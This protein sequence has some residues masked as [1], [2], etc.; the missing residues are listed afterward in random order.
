MKVTVVSG[1]SDFDSSKYQNL[2]SLRQ[3]LDDYSNVF[4]KEEIET[5]F[6]RL[7]YLSKELLNLSPSLREEKMEKGQKE[8]DELFT[9]QSEQLRSQLMREFFPD[10]LSARE[11]DL[12]MDDFQAAWGKKFDIRD[13]FAAY[14]SE[15]APVKTQSPMELF[16]KKFSVGAPSPPSPVTGARGVDPGLQQALS[17]AQGW[18]QTPGLNAT[19]QRLINNLIAEID[20]LIASGGTMS[21]L[22]TW[23]SN[24]WA[25]VGGDI[26]FYGQPN[27]R[28]W[29]GIFE[30]DVVKLFTICGSI[31]PTFSQMDDLISEADEWLMSSTLFYS[32]LAIALDAEIFSVGAQG[33]P[34][35]V[36]TWAQQVVQNNFEICPSIFED[37]SNLATF[38]TMTGATTTLMVMWE[39]VK[40]QL[41]LYPS[42]PNNALYTDALAEIN[43]LIEGGGSVSDFEQWFSSQF[44]GK[45]D[46][47]MQYL[48]FS[49]TA[50]QA[51]FD[52]ALRGTLPPP[53]AMDTAYLNAYNWRA[54]L[55]PGADYNLADELVKEIYALGS[56]AS[57]DSLIAW[58]NN[59]FATH[60]IYM[61]NPDAS[62]DALNEFYTITG[63]GPLPGITEMDKIYQYAWEMSKNYPGTPDQALFIA[64]A[65]EAYSLGSNGNPATVTAW[66]QHL[67]ESGDPDF[68][69][70]TTGTQQ[71]FINITSAFLGA[72]Y[73][74]ALEWY[75]S[76][77][78]PN[79]AA[80]QLAAALLAE[81]KSLGDQGT[82]AQLKAWFSQTFT[83]SRDVYWQYLGLSQVDANT[84]YAICQEG[85]APVPT[86]MDGTYKSVMDWIGSLTPGSAD[87]LLAQKLLAEIQT[88]GSQ[89]QQSDLTAW[90]NSIFGGSQ[91]IYMQNPDA[92]QA[93]I[94]QFYSLAGA[95]I[96]PAITAM[97]QQYKFVLN[98]RAGLQPGSADYTLANDLANEILSLGS[99]GSATA[100]TAWAQQL[101]ESGFPD[102]YNASAA[103][104]EKFVQFTSA[105]LAAAYQQAE[106]WFNSTAPNSAAH[107]LAAALLAEIKSLG[108]QG[109]VDQ[110]KAWF[111]QT[112]TASK[113]VYWQYLGL[114]QTD[115][116]TFYAICQEGGAPPPTAMDTIY[117]NVMAW[118]ASLLPG[119]ADALL[120]QKLLAEIQSLGS[121]GTQSTLNSWISNTF[122]GTQDIYMQNPDASQAAINQFYSLA[123]AGAPTAITAMDQQYK[124]AFDWRAGLQS[125]SA[126]Y[127]LADDLVNEIFSLGSS[128]SAAALTAW[129]QH[130]IE[131]G[132]PD[133]YNASA[134]AQGKFVQFT[135]AWL[136]AAYQQ[137]EDW[138][139]STAPNSAAHQ[140]AATLLAE[141]KSLGDQ[142]TVDQL[143]AWFS[144]TFTASRD[145]YWQYLGLSQADANT[146]YAICQEGGAP[147][148]TAMD[149]IY[150]NVTTWIASLPPG[151]ADALLAQK[152]LTE[153][154]SLGSQGTQ[155][156]LSGWIS[157]TFGGT[158]DIYMQNPDASQAAINQI[159]SLAGAG[160]PPTMTTMDQQYKLAFDW[161]AGLQSG[162]A[163]YVLANDLVN[164]IFSL[165]SSGSVTTLTAWAQHLIKSDFPDYYNAPSAAQE[166]FVQF[167]FAWLG[168][169]YQ[170]AEDW[171]N[172]TTPNSPARQLAIALL[173]EIQALGDQ[174]TIDQLKAWFS[175]TFSASK[176]V[177]WQ[178]LGL[179]QTDANTFYAICQEGGAPPPTAMDTIYANVMAWV[180]SLPPGTIDAL[181]AQ[182]LL[183]EVQSLGSQGTQ[184]TLNG[185]MNTTF[186]IQDIYMQNPDAS[187]TAIDQFYLLAGAG[188]P[189]PMT[190]ADQKY[191]LAYDWRATLQ[192]GSV[193][194][195]LANDLTDQ[196]FAIGSAGSFATVTAWAQGIVD[197]NFANYPEATDTAKATFE[198]IADTGPPTDPFLGIKTDIQA[199]LTE[200]ETIF[201]N[202]LTILHQPYPQTPAQ[203]Q[204]L[205]K[206]CQA[207]A[208][209]LQSAMA[210]CHT[211]AQWLALG[212]T[213][214]FTGTPQ[215]IQVAAAARV[216]AYQGVSGYQ[217]AI[218][219]FNNVLDE[220]N[221]LENERK[222]LYVLQTWASEVNLNTYSG[223]S[224][225][226]IG[227]FDKLLAL[228]Q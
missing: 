97:D 74:Q 12:Y 193:D 224:A 184:S 18:L 82:V 7:D 80:Y 150:A 220:I 44:L 217:S 5:A 75:N 86:A 35:T 177:Y 210:Q 205:I 2:N 25:S 118:V 21:D 204:L 201:S 101:I 62:W 48:G 222:P 23:L 126:D 9:Q 114:S 133:Y 108:N 120:A 40:Y 22:Q 225:A 156:A 57:Q 110:L 199:Y 84:F 52:I 157:S 107:Q 73:Q 129:A 186:G 98:W 79:S 136:A 115:A 32:D 191:K 88:L 164:E 20:Q 139:N 130:L 85:A 15:H 1:N 58:V 131:S 162:S 14:S 190:A 188:A 163:D 53:T 214:G 113:D 141:I 92:S 68:Y 227:E 8:I 105:W 91:D 42:G 36:T 49:S 161:R 81:I 209:K 153:V 218:A 142:G 175:Q 13:Y 83:T 206:I 43:K 149:T 99:S 17:E 112:F 103:A 55:S 63:A 189:P 179:S 124:L 196:I 132:F 221:M 65:N 10:Q 93:A 106:D 166:K 169:A 172:S 212:R 170:Q 181:L 76:I 87:F 123:G 202:L 89:G 78:D 198:K 158:Q 72:V 127:A 31:P 183:A 116:N 46:I 71:N 228:V 29:L 180:A 66:A 147:P 16:Q 104:Q 94:N 176:D 151:S 59:T 50:A 30:S 69:N 223:L 155:S 70:S 45:N 178:Y 27:N 119:S 128:G 117:T 154:Q 160:I 171:F 165:G 77:T 109:T 208:V 148:P 37:P 60:D 121:Q 168:A 41:T 207:E 56:G 174:G 185:W 100:L 211:D 216:A 95:G 138:F 194:Y 144:Q 51:L 19:E 54:G 140:L 96:P 26:F 192:A 173:Q 39:E 226:D 137:A 111:S 67:I 6:H 213:F 3:K 152:L 187:A 143:K 28:P 11:V 182:K 197:S 34:A 135:S 4:L 134:A 167:T 90:V 102:Y 38:L 24:F 61:Q 145:V 125:G 159:Y 146:L 64:L 122:G 195:I 33:S 203:W 200:R 47:Y 215:Q 219:L